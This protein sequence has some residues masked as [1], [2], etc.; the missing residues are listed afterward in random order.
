MLFAQTL[1]QTIPRAI[2]RFSPNIFKILEINFSEILSSSATSIFN[3][4]VSYGITDI[5]TWT[6][7]SI[8]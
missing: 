3:F 5:G 1:L 4:C 6:S 8:S 7:F 2:N